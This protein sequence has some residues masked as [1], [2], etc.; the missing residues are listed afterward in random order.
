[1]IPADVSVLLNH[2]WQE[3]IASSIRVAV[4]NAIAR[5]ADGILFTTCDQPFVDSALL[6]SLADA[7]KETSKSVVASFYGTPGIPAVF[8][9]DKFSE[10]LLL[11]GDK[12]AKRLI[13]E[14]DPHLI[15]APLAQYDIDTEKDLET[16]RLTNSKE[17]DQWQKKNA[18]ATTT[19]T[20]RKKTIFPDEVFSKEP[21]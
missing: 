16:C 13:L 8:S 2:N 15:I 21:V 17:N 12:G 14:S 20:T 6:A 3:G 9:K 7:F 1:M 19:T 11:A 10:L 4:E 18:L 5:H